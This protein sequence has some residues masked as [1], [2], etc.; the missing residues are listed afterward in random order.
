VPRI[1]RRVLIGVL[2]A[3][4]WAAVLAVPAFAAAPSVVTGASST[5]T[6]Q[7]ATLSGTVNPGGLSTEVYFQ[8]GTTNTYGA[9]SAPT[10]VAAGSKSVPVSIP[11]TGLTAG[12]TYHYRLVAT[13]STAT[14]LGHDR[15]LVT[16]KIPLSLAITAAPNPV[17]FGS[18]VTVEGT[19]S[20]TGSGGAAVQL[21]QNPFPYTGGFVDIGNP[22][23]TL[24]T[25]TFAFNV[26]SLATNTQYRVVSG[27]VAS[28]DV[29][30]SVG[31]SITLRAV[32]TGTNR[33]PS[34]RFSGMISPA[35]PSARIAFERLVGTSWKVVGG[36]V[37]SQ[38]IVNSSVGFARTVRVSKGGFFRALVLPVE[39]AHVSGYSPTAVVK[40]K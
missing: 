40:I 13:N 11:I 29:V 26:L 30:V 24:A 7:S 4:A 27:R 5:V 15:T 22:E 36:M 12:T 21:Q 20:G 23:L 34:I 1:R 8:Y 6:Y 9:Q 25:G 35:E 37:A 31:L 18:Y 28:T 10:Q 16:A 3:A 14:A 19:L 39:G 2:C 32:A 33:Q 38:N 17:A